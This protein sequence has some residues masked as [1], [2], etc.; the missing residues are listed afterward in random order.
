MAVLIKGQ[1]IKCSQA[2]RD[3]YLRGSENEHIA[4]L[5]VT[6]F[7]TKNA[8]EALQMIELSAKGTR[9]K[10]PLYSAKINP[11]TDRLWTK[12]E[13][14]QAIG[15][16]EKNLGLTNH[17]RVVVEHVKKGRVHYHVLWDRRPPEGGTAR[18]MGND[19]AIIRKTQ[20]EIEKAFKLRP[21]MAKG[22]DFKLSEVEW[23]KRYGFDIFQ[24]REQITTNFNGSKNGQF[25]MAFLKTKGIVLCR[26]DKSQF[27][28]ILPWGQHKAFSSMIHGRPT[29]AVLRRAFADIDIKKLPTIA[30]GKQQ[31][32][33]RLPK[34]L[35][36]GKAGE[37]S[38][39]TYPRK[40]I[41]SLRETKTHRDFAVRY[42]K[43]RQ[44]RNS[45]IKQYRHDTNFP[46]VRGSL[47]TKSAI[48]PIPK[49]P[50]KTITDAPPTP[51]LFPHRPVAR[52]S[53]SAEQMIDYMAACEGKI[54]WQQYFRK[55]GG[56]RL[57]P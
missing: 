26:G 38:G 36:R 55:W 21:M 8:D 37:M 11:E 54:T 18:N 24:L 2:S 41:H 53:K 1:S 29:K 19:Y 52:G 47:S 32:K 13:V 56:N 30:E 35:P 51:P 43:A 31:V 40:A 7:A 48:S 44:P 34:A 23:A 6:G 16:L 4:V 39:N 27:V 12:Q 33:A 14:M 9:C 50:V 25:F 3:H 49:P 28:L 46:N 42:S 10:K 22:R 17:A 45:G 15:M 57:S 20:C 5:D